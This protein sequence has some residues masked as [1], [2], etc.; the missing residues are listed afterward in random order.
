MTC[1]Q[2]HEALSLQGCFSKRMDNT[3]GNRAAPVL[4]FMCPRNEIAYLHAALVYR[5]E[6]HSV[7]SG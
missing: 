4:L 6:I 7:F 1:R 2:F 3:V 5:L